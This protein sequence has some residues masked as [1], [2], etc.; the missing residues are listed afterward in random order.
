MLQRFETNDPNEAQRFKRAL[1]RN[2]ITKVPA[3]VNV[4][5]LVHSVEHVADVPNPTWIITFTPKPMPTKLPLK[6]FAPRR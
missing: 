3:G 4:A 2:V 6:R 1:F 5:G